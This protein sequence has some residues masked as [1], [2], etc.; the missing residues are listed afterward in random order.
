MYL[1]LRS[2]VAPHD[3]NCIVADVVKTMVTIM[4]VVVLVVNDH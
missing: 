4:G 3:V 2:D 1:G